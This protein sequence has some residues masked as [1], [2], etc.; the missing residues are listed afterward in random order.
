MQYFF[1]NWGKF[2]HNFKWFNQVFQRY[3]YPQIRD[4]KVPNIQPL[5]CHNF[6]K[7][8]LLLGVAIERSSSDT[9]IKMV[10]YIIDPKRPQENFAK[11]INK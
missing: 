7:I 5:Q 2:E 9:N 1:N 6:V 10:I 4:F 11:K 8:I 3:S